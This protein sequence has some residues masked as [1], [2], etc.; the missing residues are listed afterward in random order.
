MVGA[1]RPPALIGGI[2]WLALAGS[3]SGSSTGSKCGT[4]NG[5]ADVQLLQQGSRVAATLSQGLRMVRDSVG[6]G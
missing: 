3:K 4:L 5:A 1:P 6:L 2:A